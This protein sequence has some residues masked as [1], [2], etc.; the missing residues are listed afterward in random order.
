MRSNIPQYELLTPRTLDEALALA[1]EGYQPFAG[2][3]DLMVLLETGKLPLTRFVSLH[4]LTDLKGIRARQTHVEIGA[5]VTYTQIRSD[6]TLRTEFPLLGL[7]A[8]ET[9]SLAIQNR[10]TLA[11]NIANAS[12]AADSSPVLLVYDAEINLISAQGVRA[13]PYSSFHTG[14][15]TTALQP[16]EIIRSIRLPRNKSHWRQTFRKVGTRK[17]QA[18]SKVVFAAAADLGTGEIRVAF[19]SVAPTPIL[20]TEIA[21]IDDLRSTARYRRK[22]AQNL[23]DEFMASLR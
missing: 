1:S 5:L 8:A 13:I 17:A 20:S 19:G 7:A 23:L 9:G 3:T 6:P 16:G 22:V 15:R 2:G 14:Y 21:P 10:G 18:I 11:G 4:N 12:P